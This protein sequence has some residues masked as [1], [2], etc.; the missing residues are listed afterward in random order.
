MTRTRIVT[1]SLF[2]LICLPQLG[3]LLNHSNHTVVRQQEPLRSVTFETEHA[4]QVFEA[5]ADEAL[6]DDANES[7][8]SFGV[9][10]LVG[11]EK[12]KTVAPNAIRNDVATK[13]DING[14]GHISEYE[15]SLQTVNSAKKREAM[16]A[17]HRK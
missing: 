2:A 1:S 12:S 11:F 10:F 17:P 13:F 16:E 4:R 15:A 14:D 9:P 6:E 3:C 5:S 8:A 7:H